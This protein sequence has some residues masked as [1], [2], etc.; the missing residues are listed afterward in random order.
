VKNLGEPHSTFAIAGIKE[1][2]I[3]YSRQTF[4]SKKVQMAL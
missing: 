1:A 4:S 3:P 2:E